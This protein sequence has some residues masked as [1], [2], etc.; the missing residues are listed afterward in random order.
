VVRVDEFTTTVLIVIGLV[1]AIAVAAIL[2]NPRRLHMKGIRALPTTPIAQI[3]SGTRGRIVGKARRAE[4]VLEAPFSGRPCF[5]WF[6]EVE[7]WKSIDGHSNWHHLFTQD[8]RV[9]LL[10]VEDDTGRA[11]IDMTHASVTVDTAVQATEKDPPPNSAAGKFMTQYAGVR[12]TFA[13]FLSRKLRFK[14]GVIADGD[15]VAALGHAARVREP[16]PNL[17]RI[18]AENGNLYVSSAYKAVAPEDHILS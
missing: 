13:E 9:P 8:Q 10:I 5:Y 1:V 12:G 14:E 17:L 4:H 2:L 18:T 11:A 3:A 16:D 7:E 6:V 15:D